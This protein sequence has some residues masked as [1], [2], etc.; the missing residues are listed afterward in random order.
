MHYLPLHFISLD[1]C[2]QVLLPAV[3]EEDFDVDHEFQF[4]Q[5][6]QEEVW[7][8]RKVCSTKRT[9]SHTLHQKT[10]QFGG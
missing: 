1:Q 8:L 6:Q 3:T 9:S 10:Y 2:M 5:L 7:I 4:R